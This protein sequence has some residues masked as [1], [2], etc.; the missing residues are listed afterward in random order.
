MS[1]S[2]IVSTAGLPVMTGRRASPDG[3]FGSA[4]E[5]DQSQHRHTGCFPLQQ[6]EGLQRRWGF[7]LMERWGQGCDAE[8]CQS[9]QSATPRPQQQ[10]AAEFVTN[11]RDSPGVSRREQSSSWLWEETLLLKEAETNR[12]C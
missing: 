3:A 8:G 9:Y 6:M 10:G 5:T 2:R 4:L 12:T 1:D 7:L 11:Q